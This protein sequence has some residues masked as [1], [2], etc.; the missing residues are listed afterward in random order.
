MTSPS[1]DKIARLK[2]KPTDG[3][4]SESLGRKTKPGHT[5]V[6]IIKLLY[7]N[8]IV[9]QKLPETNYCVFSRVGAIWFVRCF[10]YQGFLD[11]IS[12]EMALLTHQVCQQTKLMSKPLTV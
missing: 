2:R 7:K 12:L 8:I 6:H 4:V 3:P 9:I 5:G 10:P 11:C 1:L